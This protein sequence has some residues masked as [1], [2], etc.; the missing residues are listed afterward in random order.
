MPRNP[1]R[2]SRRKP[3]RVS[4]RPGHKKNAVATKK[5]LINLRATIVETKA[6]KQKNNGNDDSGAEEVFLSDAVSGTSIINPCNYG[7]VN[8]TADYNVIG[9]EMTCKYLTQKLRFRFP[10]DDK[11]IVKPYRIQVIH[12][13]ITRP[14]GF[15]PF[16]E[17]LGGDSATYGTSAT[18]SRKQYIHRVTKC[19]TAPWNE[20]EDFIDFRTKQKSIYRIIGKRW[21]RP[22]RRFMI[23]MPTNAN[24]SSGSLDGSV[25]DVTMTL[26]WPV[27]GRKWRL[28]HSTDTNDP[29][30]GGPAPTPGTAQPFYYNNENWIPFTV[31][32]CPDFANI[33]DA[34]NSDNTKKVSL[35]H[36]SK[37]WFTDS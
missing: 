20:E 30:E 35:T 32:Y 34:G 13:F 25:P 17:V 29:G 28:T 36:N 3:K 22:D 31:I 11:A 19:V 16:D 9:D 4:R 15:T 21:V 6:Y 8:G 24:A 27:K 1:R 7:Y 26:T 18:I 14:A 10:E 12:G 2:N 23:P 37:L 33:V 5:D